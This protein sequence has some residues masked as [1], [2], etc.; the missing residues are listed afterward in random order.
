MARCMG[1]V[2]ARGRV[3]V[4]GRGHQPGLAAQAVRPQRG[5]DGYGALAGQFDLFAGGGQPD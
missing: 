2:G 3:P 1:R 4:G 5:F